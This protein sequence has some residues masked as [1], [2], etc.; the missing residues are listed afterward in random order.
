MGKA[1]WN[2][3]GK[4]FLDESMYIQGRVKNN[5][6]CQTLSVTTPFVTE[7]DIHFYCNFCGL[8]IDSVSQ[9]TQSKRSMRNDSGGS[10]RGLLE[11]KP[12]LLSL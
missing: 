9:T 5:A 8:F 3:G 1:L 2:L 11:A 6:I 7:E 12:L 4:F 10:T